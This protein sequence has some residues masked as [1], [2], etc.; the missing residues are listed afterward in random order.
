[1]RLRDLASFIAFAIMIAFGIGYFGSL[2]LRIGSP[3]H[4]TDVSMKVA[5]VNGLVVGSNVLLRG[6]PV[7]KVSNIDSSVDGATVDFYL[8]D[9][10]HVPVDSDVRLENLSALGESYIALI[11]RT[12]SGPNLRDGQRIAAKS[13]IQP[14]S[15]SELATSVVRV[16]NQLD[17]GALERVV[18]EA[19][20]ALPDP[21]SALPNLSRTSRLLRN[22]AA[23]LHGHGQ[24][25]LD[26]FQTL[27][28]NAGWLGPKLAELTPEV[29]NFNPHLRGTLSTLPSIVHW[30]A[31]RILYKFDDFIDRIQKFLDNNGGDLKVL[32]EAIRPH[33]K[34][35]A[36]ALL[37]FDTG[38]ILANVLDGLPE[39]GTITLHVAIPGN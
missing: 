35:I 16:L 18:R 5:D 3:S 2:G 25:L 23:D 21:K 15:I 6:V 24:E 27:L 22:T 39:D 19:D 33:I 31:P 32:G 8:R 26:N 34:G 37:N 10:F 38:Q 13:I 12:Q 17:P 4:R 11:P 20:T 36:G 14:P 29:N 1:M 9:Q 28:R 30:G 7:G